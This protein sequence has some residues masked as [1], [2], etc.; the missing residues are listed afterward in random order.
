MEENS[1]LREQLAYHLSG[2]GAH[3]D[4]DT[5]VEGM[6]FE[7]TGKQVPKLA[8]TAWQLVYH[9]QMAQSD[10]LEFSRNPAHVSPE[11][12]S[13]YWP[14]APAPADEEQWQGTIA[15]FREDLQ[16]MIALV[17]NPDSDL[18][19]PFAHG[20]GQNLLREAILII[21]HNS[22]HIGQLVDIRMLL[23]IPVRDW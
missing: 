19:T 4:F 13:G 18:F 22:Y 5:A 11:Y 14:K 17:K 15:S 6:P 7:L 1:K 20:S 21:D 9:L 3:I 23:G 12:P 2:H 10:I 16:A 8:H